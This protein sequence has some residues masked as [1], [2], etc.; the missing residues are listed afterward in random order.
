VITTDF[1]VVAPYLYDKTGLVSVPSH[2]AYIGRIGRDGKI[3]A[4]IAFHDYIAGRVASV[5]LACEEYGLGKELLRF[6]FRYA[7]RQLGVRRL[8]STIDSGNSKSLH[9]TQRL[10]FEVE[11][12]LKGAGKTGD[13][14]CLALWKD[15]CRFIK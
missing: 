9:L 15:N 10:G 13:L 3:L 6:G 1:R 2:T 12:T 5:T 4:G 11:A 8:T 7:F 14:I